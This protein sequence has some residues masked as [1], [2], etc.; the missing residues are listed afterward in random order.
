MRILLVTALAQA[1][2]LD[3][4]FPIPF[5]LWNHSMRW[6]LARPLSALGWREALVSVP[7]TCSNS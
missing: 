4:K 3:P 2:F 7:E 5:V 6:P 1:L